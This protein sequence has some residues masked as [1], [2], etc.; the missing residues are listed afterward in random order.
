MLLF[1]SGI[2]QLRNWN[3][4]QKQLD[5]LQDTASSI[6]VCIMSKILSPIVEAGKNGVDMTYADGFVRKIFPILAAYIADYPE[7]CL[8]SCCM[9]NQCPRCVV[10]P[11]D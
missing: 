3:V 6:I 5:L 10:A 7:Q 1:S 4:I 8:V 2:F 9:E 11:N